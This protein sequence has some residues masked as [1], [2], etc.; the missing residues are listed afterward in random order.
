MKYI[1]MLRGINVG[2]KRKIIMAELRGMM[3]D[4]GYTQVRSYI[5]SGNIIFESEASEADIAST[6]QEG[7]HRVFGHQDV[8]VI[9]RNADEFIDLINT[10]PF[11]AETN[12]LHVT[13]LTQPPEPIHVSQLVNPGTDHY[14]IVDRNIYIHCLGKYHQ[15]K[16]SNTFFEKKLGQTCTTRNWKTILKLGDLIKE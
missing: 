8:P 11:D 14:H 6:I 12:E 10:Q 3:E 16:L 5:Q 2:G 9:V 7:I 4:L 13:F 1:A 15:S